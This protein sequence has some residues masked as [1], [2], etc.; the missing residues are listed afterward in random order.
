LANP[1]IHYS[2]TNDIIVLSDFIL[3]NK[4]IYT[5][6]K[7]YSQ[8]I[9]SRPNYLG[10][11]SIGIYKGNKLTQI[12]DINFWLILNKYRFTTGSTSRT[13]NGHRHH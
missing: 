2:L 3:Y 7:S 6:S 8:I 11:L 4:H 10:S 13:Y 9:R 5:V 12:N 1:Q